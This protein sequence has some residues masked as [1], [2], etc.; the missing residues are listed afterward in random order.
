MVPETVE[1]TFAGAPAGPLEKV[2][3]PGMSSVEEVCA[4]LKIP[5]RDFL[6]TSVFQ[7]ES[8]I[9]V[10]WVV[11]V[12]RGDHQIDQR[13]LAEAA[14]DLGVVSLKLAN[15]PQAGRKFALG[16]V[17]ADAGTKTPDAV[18]IVDVAAAQ[19]ARA[20]ATGANETDF[21]VRNFNWFRDAGD[22][23]ANPAKVSVADISAQ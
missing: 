4:Y 13:K 20:W 16:Y 22:Q 2:H 23:L 21:H 7:A 12:V 15:P 14:R 8:P 9:R 11:S 17:G 6:K 10:N 19:G 5:L 18:L 3:T 1:W